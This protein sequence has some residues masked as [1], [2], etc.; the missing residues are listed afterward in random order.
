MHHCNSKHYY[1]T[2]I[3]SQM[4][5]TDQ[6]KDCQDLKTDNLVIM[7]ISSP[8]SVVLIRI[9]MGPDENITPRC[10]RG[11]RGKTQERD[12][13]TGGLPRQPQSRHTARSDGTFDVTNA[14]PC[15]HAISKSMLSCIRTDRHTDTQPSVNRAPLNHA[16]CKWAQS[17]SSIRW[18]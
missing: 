9:Q 15:S 2:E 8:N 6:R 3:T 4:W 1:N 16:I 12:E 10:S 18:Q 5:P 7:N 17:Q 13:H 14:T 11:C